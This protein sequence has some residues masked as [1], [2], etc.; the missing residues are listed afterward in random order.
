[1]DYAVYFLVYFVRLVLSLL[2]IL[3]F[4]RIIMSWFVQDGSSKVYDFLYYATEPVVCPVRKLLSKFMP[5]GFM[6]DI[7][8]LLTTI[9]LSV[10]Q[11]LLPVVTL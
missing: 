9:L 5:D 3:V 2:Q 8:I 6:I 1:M 4:A 10:V 11:I 7:S